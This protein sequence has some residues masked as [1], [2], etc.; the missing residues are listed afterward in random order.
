MTYLPNMTYQMI[1]S[2][3]EALPNFMKNHAIRG[4]SSP[5]CYWWT[6]YLTRSRIVTQTADI[7]IDLHEDIVC[8]G[9]DIGDGLGSGFMD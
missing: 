9:H 6:R 5:N 8:L 3:S 1:V 2:G 7:P 4:T